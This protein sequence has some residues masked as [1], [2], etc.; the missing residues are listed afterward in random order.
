ML[1]L[2]VLH[3]VALL[4]LLFVLMKHM[5]TWSIALPLTP[6]K[7][8]YTP[9]K[10]KQKQPYLYTVVAST[11]RIKIGELWRNCSYKVYCFYKM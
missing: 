3:N 8:N 6:I 5:V 4:V 11:I 2:Y 9:N 1:F 10:P 7:N